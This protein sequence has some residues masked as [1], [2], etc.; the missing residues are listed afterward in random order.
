MFDNTKYQKNW[1]EINKEKFRNYKFN[2]TQ[3]LHG[4]Y[5]ATKYSSNR[6]KIKFSLTEEQFIN[7]YKEQ[8]QECYYCKRTIQEVQKDK[9]L[10]K[11]NYR[12]SIDRKN[13]NKGYKL[14][15]IV[16]SCLNCNRIKTDFFTEQEM[17]VIGKILHLIFANR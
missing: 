5:V 10:N 9:G 7:W 16:L 14:G 12:L 17:L 15:N 8:K 4:I 13:N 2:Y 6:R 1:R 11:I 3:S